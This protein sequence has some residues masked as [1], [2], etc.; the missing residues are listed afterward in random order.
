MKL[1]R[2]IAVRNKKTVYR[3]G[4]LCIKVFNED[5]S[6]SE[7]FNEATNRTIIEETGL[8][9]PK[10]L[11][12]TKVDEKWA[13]VYENIKGKS[14]AQLMKENPDKK[15]EYIN[16]L[17]DIHMTVLSQNC[18]Q[19]A[20]M[21]DKM[22]QGIIRCELDANTRYD[23]HTRLENMP[24]QSKLC[25]GDFIPSNIIITEEGK[26]YIVDWENA[27]QGNISSDIAKTYLRFCAEGDQI[28]ADTYL[29][30]MCEKSGVTKE[31][32]EKWLPL[33]AAALSVEG[34]ENNRDFMLSVVKSSKY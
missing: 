32:I 3:D 12:V 4:N 14:L 27:T 5:Y 18:P 15:N 1:D 28:S 29:D 2:I 23:M 16:M 34:N 25:H 24:K 11:E 26:A 7:I 33:M 22:T 20:K 8:N 13:I 6:K 21:K 30:I 10:V 9:V 31:A 19:L 17:A